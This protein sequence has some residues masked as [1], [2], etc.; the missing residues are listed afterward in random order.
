[1]AQEKKE[2]ALKEPSIIIKPIG[3][4]GGLDNLHLML[5]I[6]VVLLFLVLFVVASHFNSYIFITANNSTGTCANATSGVNCTGPI[7]SAAQIRTLA[8]RMLA[9]YANVNSS[10]SLL[11]FIT[12]VSS[13]NVSYLQASRS[14]YVQLNAKNFVNNFAFQVGFLI[15]DRNTSQITP[16]LQTAKPSQLSN[17]IEVAAGVIQLSGGYP[18]L[19]PVPTQVYWFVDP[20]AVGSVASLLNASEI[21]QMYGSKVNLALKAVDGA[22]TQR[23]SASVGLF[24]AVYLSKYAL[25]ASQQKNFSSFAANLNSAYNGSYM[26]QSV[27]AK[28]ANDSKLNNVQLNACISASS[29]ELGA[30]GL[31]AE[32][33]NITQTPSVVVGC[34][35]LALP[36]TTRAALCYTNSTLC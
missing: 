18:C 15:N 8:E 4:F 12:N 36:Q 24:N 35:Y 10:L 26:P 13:M 11:P 22:D 33:Y 14:W 3:R 2:K 1:M 29:T 25:C 23:I 27:L 19:T 20:Y 9:S 5:I 7:H 17:N 28:I 32:Q 34:Q 31:L 16:F 6:L 21:M 30:Q